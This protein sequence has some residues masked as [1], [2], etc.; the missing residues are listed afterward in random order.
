MTTIVVFR[1]QRVNCRKITYHLEKQI[2]YSL[3][4]SLLLDLIMCQKSLVN[5]L[6]YPIFKANFNI[7]LKIK[8]R[9][10]VRTLRSKFRTKFF[11]VI[12]LVNKNPTYVTLCRYLFTAKL[13][14][15]FRVSQHPSSGVLKTAPAA[16]G[17]SSMTC[18]GGCGCSF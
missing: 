10:S 13:L 18:T 12:L 15:I 14:Y 17:T 3:Q 1:R 16:S 9:L 6:D 4:N 11:Y 2:H 5:A 8:L 7:I